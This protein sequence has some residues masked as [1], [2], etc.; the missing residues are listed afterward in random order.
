[1][2]SRLVNARSDSLSRT[3]GEGVSTTV[4]G[5]ALAIERNSNDSTLVIDASPFGKR[6]GETLAID[7]VVIDEDVDVS[8]V[9]HNSSFIGNSRGGRI[10]L[11]T[12]GETLPQPQPS[13]PSWNELMQSYQDKFD[14]VIFDLGSW[15]SGSP[16]RWAT[17][18]G[19]LV[20]VIDGDKTTSDSLEEFSNILSKTDCTVLGFLMNNK[21]N[22]IPKFIDKLIR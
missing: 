10:H 9:G 11:M 16:L 8:A 7:S 2:D 3:A 18:I 22:Y 15:E 1:M 20:V 14:N 6:I 21:K 19:S 4:A 12:L 5:L 13:S 17:A